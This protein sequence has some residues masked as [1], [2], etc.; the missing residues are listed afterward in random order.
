M[1]RRK[2]PT[3]IKQLDAAE[4]RIEHERLEAEIGRH[5]ERYY[6]EDAP[7]FSDAEYNALRRRYEALEKAFPQLVTKQSLN[8][9]VGSA[10]LEKFAKV[11]HKA[12]VLS[13][14]NVFADAEV[15]DFVAR[16]RRF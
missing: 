13:L 3:P 2:S 10:P 4:A 5:D 1:Q 15:E 6:R 7:T 16:I 11:R 12:P 9:R 8:E 14:G